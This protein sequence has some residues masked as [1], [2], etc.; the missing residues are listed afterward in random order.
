MKYIILILIVT[1]KLS[2]LDIYLNSAKQD[3]TPYAI[4]HIID[5][6]DIE[7]H[8][9]LMALDKKSYI[10]KFNKIVKS[11]I[12]KKKMRFVDIDFLE[13]KKEFYIK[14][15]P[16][17]NSSLLSLNEEL[18]RVK[19]VLAEKKSKRSKHWVILL[20]TKSLF[21]KKIKNDGINFPVTYDSH[22]MPSVGPVDLNGAPI[23]YARSKDIN[24]YLDIQKEFRDGDY[25]SVVQDAKKVVK[26]YPN[27]IFMSDILLYKIKSIDISLE[28]KLL[29][30]SDKYE[31]SDL[32]KDA[33]QWIRRYASSENIPQM[34]L[35]LVKS[36]L[37]TQSKADVNYFLDIMINEHKNS[38]YTKRAILYYADSLYKRNKKIEATK[39]YEDVLY[40]AKNL[41]IA[42]LAAIK[43]TNS[44]INSGNTKEAKEYLMKVLDANKK[45]LLKDFKSTETLA[46]KLAA[47][48]LQNIAGKLNDL[49][50]KNLPKSRADEKEL[51]LKDAGDWYAEANQV[52]KAYARYTQYQKE[53]KDGIYIDEITKARDR[54]FF[55][56]KETN[57]T[58]LSNYY[59]LLIKKYDNDIRDKAILYKAKLLLKEKRYQEVLSMKKQ[60]K[61]LVENNSTKSNMIIKKASIG[62]ISKSLKVEDCQKAVSAFMDNN[63]S[64]SKIDNSKKLFKCFMVMQEY[65]YAN[66]LSK[67]KIDSKELNKKMIWLENLIISDFKLQK[68]NEV[69]KVKKD[70]FTL[71]K[72]INKK[73]KP[74]VYRAIFN[75]YYYTSSYSLALETLHEIELTYPKDIKNLDL[76]YK[77]VNYA[78]DKRDDLL[79]IK[80]AKKI[81]SMQK[82]YKIHSYS[83]KVELLYIDALKRVSRIKEAREVA[84]ALLKENSKKYQSRILYNIGELSLKL[85]DKKEAKRY[86]LKCSKI[87]IIDSW[88]S[89]C[90]DSLKL[91]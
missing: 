46:K 50:L 62:L 61:K 86:F 15:D 70:I 81:I 49:L 57:E 54:L 84:K 31:N 24:Y 6:E 38:P 3:N 53:Y 91:F 74:S 2:A 85:N 44:K 82:I 79:L 51:L 58:K 80:Y 9:V 41:D 88:V 71:A 7:C 23:A 55:H 75:S 59:D 19:E 20:F 40:S 69:I 10:C 42:S 34:L 65:R 33:K 16:K 83:P 89:L 18:Y 13:K 37:R 78:N 43:L 73:I 21:G 30:L 1:L 4:L 36:Y 35:V 68:F 5:S 8:T 60:L 76:Y 25:E 27:S 63:I 90:S 14:I 67:I 72:V 52:E 47:N 22:L 32:I 77:I 48:R 66:E 29:P 56:I 11:K 26:Q 17:F 28:K 64:F 39:L 45:Y 12:S 87:A